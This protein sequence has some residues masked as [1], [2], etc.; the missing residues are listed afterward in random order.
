MPTA[1]FRHRQ[2]LLQLVEAY[3]NTNSSAN[4]NSAYSAKE[5]KKPEQRR[6]RFKE[7]VSIRPSLHVNDITE[8]EKEASWFSPQEFDRMKED[9][10]RTV[11]L[12]A[13]GEYE[14]GGAEQ[15]SRGLEGRTRTECLQRRENKWAA[16]NA[17]LDE[18][19]QQQKFQLFDDELLREVYIEENIDCRQPALEMGI[20]DHEDASLQY[21]IDLDANERESEDSAV[22]SDVDQMRSMMTAPTRRITV[23]SDYE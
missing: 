18:Q 2:T 3:T 17:V 7:T 19:D 6:V 4:W 20:R 23:V 16:I 21:E 1:N 15:C 5:Y 11:E 10:S 9:V 13:A 12:M 8:D 22:Y 14:G